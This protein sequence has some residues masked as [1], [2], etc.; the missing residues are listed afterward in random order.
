MRIITIIESFQYYGMPSGKK[1]YSLMRIQVFYE[2]KHE[3]AFQEQGKK[4]T[5][6]FLFALKA[7]SIL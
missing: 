4:P 1:V 2:P 5:L 6:N 7:Y 3:L